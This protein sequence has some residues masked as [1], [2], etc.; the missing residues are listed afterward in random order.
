MS[1]PPLGVVDLGDGGDAEAGDAEAGDGVADG[2]GVIADGDGV[3]AGDGEELRLALVLAAT[4]VDTVGI[5][6][7]TVTMVVTM[8]AMVAASKVAR[9]TANR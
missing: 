5:R 9:S 3:Q 8:A 7:M 1:R 2:D 4:M 6:M